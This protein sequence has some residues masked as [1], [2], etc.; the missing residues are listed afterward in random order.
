MRPALVTVYIFWWSE[1]RHASSNPYSS[2]TEFDELVEF[3]LLGDMFFKFGFTY[4]W[5]SEHVPDPCQVPQLPAVVS[6]TPQRPMYLLLGL[7]HKIYKR[8]IDQSFDPRNRQNKCAHYH[9]LVYPK[10]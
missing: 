3:R 2:D 1:T 4:P 6:T 8:H 9:V 7:T 5:A 10:R